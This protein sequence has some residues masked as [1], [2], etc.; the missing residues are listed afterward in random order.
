MIVIAALIL[1]EITTLVAIAQSRTAQTRMKG[2]FQLA[3][4]VNSVT[5]LVAAGDPAN[6]RALVAG[7][8]DS[9]LLVRVDPT[10]LASDAKDETL[11]ELERVLRARLSRFVTEVRVARHQ[12]EVVP[13]PTAAGAPNP[14]GPFEQAFSYL[15]EQYAVGDAYVVSTRLQDGTWINVVNSIPGPSNLWSLETIALTIGGIIIVVAASTWAL[16]QLTGPYGVLARGA[17]RFGV[18]LNTPPLAERGPREVRSAV[19][20]FNLMRGR[21]KRMIEDRD[22]LVAAVSHDLRTPVTRLRLR[23]E[24]VDDPVQKERMLADLADIETLTQ[25]VLAFASGAAKPEPRQL[26]DLVSLLESLC[27]DSPEVELR[28][29][30]G[31]PSR[32]ACWAQPVGLRRCLSNLLDNA[33]RYGRHATVSLS[34]ADDIARITVDDEGPGMSEA[35]LEEVFRPFVRLETSRNR[36]TGGTGLGLTIARSV[37]RAHGG[38]VTLANRPDC[39]LRAEVTLPLTVPVRTA[40]AAVAPDLAPPVIVAAEPAE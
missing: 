3:E 25:S 19:R 9:T 4:R 37:A 6:R 27:A 22:H 15:S 30:E 35:S 34:V 7:L 29:A 20:A 38:D 40:V 33:M 1:A 18:D 26:L 32:V 39:G 17:D 13:R 14:T 31:L 5:R 2:L 21:L 24:F 12:D 10:P 8:G 28:L 11:G 23:A 36:E 16:R